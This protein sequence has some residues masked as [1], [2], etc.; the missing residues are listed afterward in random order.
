MDL[1]NVVIRG[2]HLQ[3]ASL[4]LWQSAFW[5][6]VPGKQT[7]S[8]NPEAEVRCR[9]SDQVQAVPVKPVTLDAVSPYEPL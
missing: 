7:A 9:H 2:C 5:L 8:H 3:E 4:A 1:T 6:R